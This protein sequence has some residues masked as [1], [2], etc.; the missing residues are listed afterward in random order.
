MEEYGDWWFDPE[1]N[2]WY[3]WDG[4]DF[5]SFDEMEPPGGWYESVNA[6][7]DENNS[8]TNSQPL[9]P[10]VLDETNNV[11]VSLKN[12][13]ASDSWSITQFLKDALA[14]AG[15]AYQTYKQV[16]SKTGTSGYMR[17]ADGSYTYRQADGSIVTV[18]PDGTRS[19]TRPN[20]QTVVTDANGNSAFGTFGGLTRDT[21]TMLMIGAGLLAVFALT[22]NKGA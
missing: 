13:G 16:T 17:N 5:F 12:P 20:G 22:R 21:K 1:T 18:R 14:I 4:N 19:I 15:S 11:V 3:L 7:I 10:F 9:E 2:E 8:F 6:L